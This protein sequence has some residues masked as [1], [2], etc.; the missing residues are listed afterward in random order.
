M[1]AAAISPKDLR[2]AALIENRKGDFRVGGPNRQAAVLI[3]IAIDYEVPLYNSLSGDDSDT[4]L[5]FGRQDE[6]QSLMDVP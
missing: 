1:S 2:A 4:D 5:V 3:K 6:F